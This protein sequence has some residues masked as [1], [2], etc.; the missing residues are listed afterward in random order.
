MLVSLSSY[1]KVPLIQWL[2]MT[3]ICSLVLWRSAIQKWVPSAAAE[4]AAGWFLLEAL[5][6]IQVL[7]FQVA[8]ASPLGGSLF[9]SPSLHP[10]DL[11]LS[12]GKNSV[13]LFENQRETGRDKSAIFYLLAHS[14]DST[15]AGV[16]QGWT[17]SLELSLVYKNQFLGRTSFH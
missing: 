14:S 15:T 9:F 11:L 10:H 2:Q 6:M 4:W 7:A 5:G 17:C 12:C 16:G 8:K 3:Y 1:D 13:N